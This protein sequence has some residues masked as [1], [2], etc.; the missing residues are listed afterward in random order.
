MPADQSFRAKEVSM[1]VR[2]IRQHANGALNRGAV[3]FIYRVDDFPLCEI[4]VRPFAT[5]WRWEKPPILRAFNI[6]PNNKLKVMF[7]ALGIKFGIGLEW[8]PL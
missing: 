3:L 2:H 1:T 8:N 6:S 7:V 5:I 4:I